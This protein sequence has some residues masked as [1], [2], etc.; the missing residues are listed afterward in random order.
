M[1]LPP[2]EKHNNGI[3]KLEINGELE[4]NYFKEK[5]ETPSEKPFE[6]QLAGASIHVSY[7]QT[8]ADTVDKASRVLFPVLFTI[9]NIVYWAVY[10]LPGNK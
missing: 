2:V 1:R 5:P 9:Y 7:R 6:D 10:A 3:K 4:A 8:A